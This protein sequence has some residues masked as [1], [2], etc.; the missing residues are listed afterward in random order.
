MRRA[1]VIVAIVALAILLGACTDQDR[2]AISDWQ[3][4]WQELRAT[5]PPAEE[6]GDPPSQTLC[7]SALGELRERRVGVV[8]TPDAAI[9]PVVEEWIRVAEAALFECPP[10]SEEIPSLD[11]AYAELARLEA[12]VATVLRLDTTS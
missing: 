3:E 4:D 7:S 11:Q 2:P 8:P 12:E 5:M 9:D 1:G 10:S 6:L